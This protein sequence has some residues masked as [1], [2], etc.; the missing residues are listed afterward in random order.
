MTQLALINIV[1]NFLTIHLRLNQVDVLKFIVLLMS[2]RITCVFQTEHLNLSF[3][4]IIT[5]IN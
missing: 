1:K 3:F 5:E 4:K 2:Y